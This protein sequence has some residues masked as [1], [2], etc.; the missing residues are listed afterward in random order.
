MIESKRTA[1]MK[2]VK[3]WIIL[4]SMIFSLGLWT[5]C[6]EDYRD[7]ITVKMICTGG[8]FSGFMLTDD[9]A[10]LVFDNTM[11][12]PMA[13][14]TYYYEHTFDNMN[15]LY[16]SATIE[17]LKDATISILVYRETYNKNKKV[18]EGTLT[19]TSTSTARTL[20]VSYEYN[21]ENPTTTTTTSKTTT[22]GTTTTK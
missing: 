16:A 10:P 2:R 5:S 7:P 15:T 3:T 22:G 11:I 13:G 17:P 1:H 14:S 21:E 6:F 18:K 12:T 19:V 20:A 4:A 8:K 9:E